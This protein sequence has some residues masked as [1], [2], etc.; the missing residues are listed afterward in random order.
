MLIP[1]R[2]RSS[3]RFARVLLA[4]GAIAAA[5]P[6]SDP[7]SR[8]K[9][10]LLLIYLVYALLVVFQRHLHRH[11]Q[12][13]PGYLIDSASF[14]VCASLE[15]MYTPVLWGAFFLYAMIN[16]LLFCSFWHVLAVSSVTVP[17]FLLIR[18][19]QPATVGAGFVIAVTLVLAGC[20]QREGLMDRLIASS[21]Q[22]AEFH[23]ESEKAR[24]AER[25]RIAA[26]F[27]DGPLQSFTSFQMRLEIVRKLLERDPEAAMSEVLR[28]QDLSRSQLQE[29]RAF[30]R[31]MRPV[32][33]NGVGFGSALRRVIESFEQESGIP[34]SLS[35]SAAVEWE[36]QEVSREVLKIVREALHNAQKHSRASRVAVTMSNSGGKVEISIRDDGTGFPF[37][38]TYQLEELDSL[39]LGPESI[40]RRVR[41]LEG[42]LTVESRPGQG[43][44]LRIQVPA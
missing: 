4:G 23:A 28:L 27:H 39:G 21:R 32:Q 14:L 43:A 16:A 30:V 6:A 1:L 22:A 42:E 15:G 11:G 34:T 13:L 33:V 19:D 10:A 24:E 25:E 17:A 44:E 31:N 40:K 41:A 8:L 26:D 2:W 35:S 12:T 5:M 18:P 7:F 29:I 37:A 9:L 20:R 38:G 3:L 36:S